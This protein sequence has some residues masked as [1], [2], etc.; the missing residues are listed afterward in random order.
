MT[1]TIFANVKFLILCHRNT[2]NFRKKV[3]AQV[4]FDLTAEVAE[5]AEKSVDQFQ[6]ADCRL[7]IAK[8]KICNRQSEIYNF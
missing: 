4:F 1:I 2:Q 5:N 8:P 3:I 6:I 7:Q